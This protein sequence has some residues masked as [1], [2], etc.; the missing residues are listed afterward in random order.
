MKPTQKI[1]YIGGKQE[2]G[3]VIDWKKVRKEWDRLN[4]PPEYDYPIPDD[5]DVSK[6]GYIMD[7]SDRSRG[8]TT[9]KLI[10]GG[11]LYKMYGIKLHYL[12]QCAATAEPKLIKDLY[13]TML[14]CEYVQKIYGDGWNHI[15]Y[16]GR[17][18][19]LQ[20]LDDDGK[21]IEQDDDFCTICLGCDEAPKLK[22]KYN[23]PRGDLI[24]Y[25]EFITDYYGYNDFKWFTDLCKTIIRDRQSP[26]IFMS[27]NTIDRQSRWFDEFVIRPEVEALQMGDHCICCTDLGTHIYVRI[28][29]PDRS[30]KR[31]KV[32]RRF[33]G[34]NNPR[35]N[36]ISGRGEWATESFP[37]IPS[38][39]DDKENGDTVTVQEVR[40]YLEHQGRLL[41]LRIIEHS[42]IGLCVYVTPA[43]RTYPDSII[44]TVE[45]ITD[46]RHIFGTAKGTAAEL[47]WLLYQRNLWFY[48][49]NSLGMV[50]RSYT[51]AMTQ[52]RQ[53]MRV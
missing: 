38:A 16:Y 35:L 23:C 29:A 53:R 33:W 45:E 52:S 14:S 19:Y 22:S 24:F 50:I 4:I 44:Y 3:I 42:R 17:R 13:D 46:R 41:W 9:G 6:V 2:N 26:L 51:L 8:K 11:V 39:K 34:F 25:D 5:C 27:A 36:A 43:S 40:L 48:S 21:V 49:S 37:H 30:E 31:E 1:K 10:L 47:P 15:I 12:V 7:M 32:N 18:W 28:F 20:K